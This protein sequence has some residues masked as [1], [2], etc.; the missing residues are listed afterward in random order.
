M[1]QITTDSF[2]GKE[3]QKN[4]FLNMSI[5]R[6]D[7]RSTLQ[8]AK[9]IGHALY[10]TTEKYTVRSEGIMANYIDQG[11]KIKIGN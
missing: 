2:Y 8:Q 1:S 4:R 5:A 6:S 10:T 11:T 7:F 9:E 3:L